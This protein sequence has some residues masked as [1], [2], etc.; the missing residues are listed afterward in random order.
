M[1]VSTSSIK[2]SN[3]RQHNNYSDSSSSPIQLD[4]SGEI[5]DSR[6]KLTVTGEIPLRKLPTFSNP[7]QRTIRDDKKPSSLW[8]MV[9]ALFFV[10]M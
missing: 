1:G 10:F 7:P 8:G 6:T 9:R 3:N 2:N 5:I 4:R